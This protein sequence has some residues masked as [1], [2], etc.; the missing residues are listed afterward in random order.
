VRGRALLF[1]VAMFALVSVRLVSAQDLDRLDRTLP[2][3]LPEHPGNVFL[4]GEEVVVPLPRETPGP[5]RVAMQDLLQ[6]ENWRFYRQSP[7][8]SG[9]LVFKR[10]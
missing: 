2:K 1:V 6:N 9:W 8:F 5:W 4:A 7:S 3:P 10:S